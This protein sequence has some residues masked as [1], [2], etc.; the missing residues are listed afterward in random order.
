V[1]TKYAAGVVTDGLTAAQL[2][3]QAAANRYPAQMVADREAANA[4]L[5][6]IRLLP[7]TV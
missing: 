2:R 4:L 3:L 7:S 5:L 1:V 6:Q